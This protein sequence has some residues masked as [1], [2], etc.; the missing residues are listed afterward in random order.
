MARWLVFGVLKWCDLHKSSKPISKTGKDKKQQQQ[1]E[2]KTK[3]TKNARVKT[4]KKQICKQKRVNETIEM[5]NAI[6][7]EHK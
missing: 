6:H 3:P 4:K 7:D 1:R 5:W 2:T